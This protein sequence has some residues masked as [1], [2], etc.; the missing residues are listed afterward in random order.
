MTGKTHMLYKVLYVYEETNRFTYFYLLELP[1][2]MFLN[3]LMYQYSLKSTA[4]SNIKPNY[5]HDLIVL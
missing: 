5:F 3:E 2:Q 4:A 1:N